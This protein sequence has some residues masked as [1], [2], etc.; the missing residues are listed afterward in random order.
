MPASE[1]GLK[2][3]RTPVN[4][5]TIFSINLFLYNP[6]F[7]RKED[8]YIDHH[9]MVDEVYV[10]WMSR[11]VKGLVILKRCLFELITAGL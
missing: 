9:C 1:I 4:M 10:F 7:D 11:S 8:L 6:I 3:E 5:D 2:L